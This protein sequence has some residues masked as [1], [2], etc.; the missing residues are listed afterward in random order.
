VG[1]HSPNSA[2]R[3]FFSAI[4]EERPLIKRAE[5]LDPSTADV[6]GIQSVSPSILSNLEAEAQKPVLVPPNEDSEP[7]ASQE[8]ADAGPG[9]DI[10]PGDNTDEEPLSTEETPVEPELPSRLTHGRLLTNKQAHPLQIFDILNMR[11]QEEW[12]EWEPETLWWALRRDFGPVGEISRNKIM[13]LRLAASTDAPW[14]DWDTFENSTLAWNNII[15]LFGAFQPVSSA[16][17]AFG[18]FVLRSIR[19][20]EEFS[21]E[22]RAYVAAMLE[23]DGLVYAPAEWFDGAQEIIDRKIWLLGFKAEV[24]SAW[25]KI[26][27]LDPTHIEWDDSNPVDVHLLK[28]FVIKQY[29]LG[30][31]LVREKIP[32]GAGSFAGVSPPVPP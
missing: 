10:G 29:M 11:Y 6:L 12:I 17:A 8:L 21:W 19:G 3:G 13:A 5:N 26:S 9:I 22:V 4:L 27:E 31:T 32:G 23:E 15:P 14:L 24:E 20:D 25:K 2:E 1:R 18:V 28:L 30:K 16:Q 7:E